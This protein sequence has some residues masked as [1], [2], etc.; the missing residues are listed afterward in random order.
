[1]AE[2]AATNNFAIGH[3]YVKEKERY[4]RADSFPSS[5]YTIWLGNR[6]GPGR[7]SSTAADL[8]KWD[9]ALYT[10]KLVKQATLQDAFTPMKLEDGKLSNYGFGWSL[11]TDS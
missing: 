7:I 6:K 8:L 10:N 2:K 9:K 5:D 4:V 1:M 3:I 11:R